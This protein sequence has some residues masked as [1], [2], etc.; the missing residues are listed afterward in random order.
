FIALHFACR[1]TSGEHLGRMIVFAAQILYNWRYGFKEAVA[2][3]E[4]SRMQREG[5][6][7]GQKGRRQV[8][9]KAWVADPLGFFLCAYHCDDAAD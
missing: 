1:L 3:W 8:D 2:A 6:P 5:C 4:K 7:V 9:Q